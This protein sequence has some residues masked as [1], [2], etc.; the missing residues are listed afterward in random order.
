MLAHRLRRWLN[1]ETTLRQRFVFA[2]IVTDY[3]PEMTVAVSIAG[4]GYMDHS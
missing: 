4:C 2:G 3:T 1:I